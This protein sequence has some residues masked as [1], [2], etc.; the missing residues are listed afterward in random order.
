MRIIKYLTVF[1]LITSCGVS[2]KRKEYESLQIAIKNRT[3]S[4]IQITLYPKVS[5][6]GGS[7]YPMC[8]GC[9]LNKETAYV[10]G[11]KKREVVGWEEVIFFTQNLNVEPYILASNAFDSIYIEMND[12]QIIFTHEDVTGYAENIFSENSNWDFVVENS[13]DK[14]FQINIYHQHVFLILEDKIIINKED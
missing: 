13:D 5:N 1:L 2:C 11:P 6:A 7:L 14:S 10:L 3:G 12:H 8:E 4:N 9:G